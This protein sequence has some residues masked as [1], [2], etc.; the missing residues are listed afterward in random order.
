MPANEGNSG[1]PTF[2]AMDVSDK[3]H[4]MSTSMQMYLDQQWQYM[5]INLSPNGYVIPGYTA[6]EI[7]A[8]G[9]NPEVLVGTMW[10]DNDNTVLKFKKAAGV[11]HT[12]TSAP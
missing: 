12:I 9:N 7:T 6:A 5:N 11:I 2:H 4:G 10:F 1:L 8:F 3:G